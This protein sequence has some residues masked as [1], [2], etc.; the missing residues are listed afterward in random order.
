MARI[1]LAQF[2]SAWMDVRKN[3]E[4]MASMADATKKE[5]ADILVFPELFSTGYNLGMMGEKIFSLAQDIHGSTVTLAR[6]KA[7]EHGIHMVPS[8]AYR[9]G[10]RIYNASVVIDHHGEVLQVY[11]KNHLWEEE[12]K[13]FSFGD[14]GYQVHETPFGRIGFLICYDVDFPETSRMLALKGA[15]DIFVSSAWSA[16]HRHLWDI[17]LPAR[18]LENTVYVAGVNRTGREGEEVFFG[19]SRVYGPDGLLVASAGENTEE[20]LYC[21]IDTGS[22][23]E[24]R[25]HFPY[26]KERRQKGYGD[27]HGE[28]L[29]E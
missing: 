11:K 12:Q 3:D 28:D 24:V 26:L 29:S 17:F 5:G 19:S 16:T 25:K 9:E 20:I 14:H 18:A 4:K 6:S 23:D 7:R 1:A 27:I 13:Y 21:N 10:G 22:L 2:D 15:Q 8:I